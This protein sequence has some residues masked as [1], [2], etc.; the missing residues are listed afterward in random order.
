MSA[1]QSVGDVAAVDANIGT[2]DAMKME[3]AMTAPVGGEVARL[4]INEMC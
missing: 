2:I 1:N 3:A 4:A